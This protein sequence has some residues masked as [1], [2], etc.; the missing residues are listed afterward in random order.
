MIQYCD[1]ELKKIQTKFP[2]LFYDNKTGFVK[3]ELNFSNVAYR[4]NH[5]NNWVIEQYQANSSERITDCYEIEIRFVGKIPE[6]YE[7]A[8]RIKK[9]AKE[10]GKEIIDYH[11]YP[12]DGRCCLTIPTYNPSETLSN[13]V[14][15]K[16]YPYFVWQAYYEKY[17]QIPPCGEYSHGKKG[18][19][20][21]RDDIK[22][23][24]VNDPCPCNSGKKYKHCCKN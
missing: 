19:I 1:K 9:L 24:G 8:G 10:R 3:G 13:F 17:N 11:Q 12:Q 14:L 20:E 6:V 15:Q 21:F 2:N 5:R 7:T 22:N 4:L 16:V 18:C 23:T